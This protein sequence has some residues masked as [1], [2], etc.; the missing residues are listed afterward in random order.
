M[1]RTWHENGLLA[2]EVPFVHGRK[3]GL[4]RAWDKEGR[5]ASE[6]RYSE[7]Q[8]DGR[9]RHWE[10]GHLESETEYVGGKL[11]GYSID[12]DEFG[13]V[14][15]RLEYRDGKPWNGVFVRSADLGWVKLEYQDGR[16]VRKII[17]P[18]G[19]HWA[20]R[21]GVELDERG[22]RVRTSD[23]NEKGGCH[24]PQPAVE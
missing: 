11:H 8:E 22:S 24:G 23:G 7:A 3:H 4:F 14:I 16:M 12:Y 10:E 1:S 2:A 21:G 5:L 17:G 6:G 20:R 13:T 19:L 18:W 15:Q 9:W